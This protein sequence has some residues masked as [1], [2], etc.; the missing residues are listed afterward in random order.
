[1]SDVTPVDYWLGLVQSMAVR[2]TS[3]GSSLQQ[4]SVAQISP[5]TFKLKLSQSVSDY[6]NL[7]IAVRLISNHNLMLK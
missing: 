3:V 7:V 1:M 2:C 6:C 5:T 4:I